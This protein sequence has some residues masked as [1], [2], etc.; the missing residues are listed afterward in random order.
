MVLRVGLGHP[1]GLGWPLAIPDLSGDM[2]GGV[3]ALVLSCP[4]VPAR[5][6]ARLS[7]RHRPLWLPFLS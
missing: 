4:T 5:G 1:I 3:S 6:D 7:L 2:R